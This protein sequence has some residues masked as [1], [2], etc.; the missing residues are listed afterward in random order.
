MECNGTDERGMLTLQVT[1][2]EHA[3]Y[4]NVVR[5]NNWRVWMRQ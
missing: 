1:D 3:S 5:V 2:D 4:W